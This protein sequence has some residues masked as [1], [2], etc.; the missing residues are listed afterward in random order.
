VSGSIDY[1]FLARRFQIAGGNIK[2]VAL[3]AA[4]LA[5]ENGGM[6]EMKH[7]LHGVRREFEKMGKL[8]QDDVVKAS[9]L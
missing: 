7:V 5:A 8:W 3:N 4:F 1:E 2:N 6:I 9:R